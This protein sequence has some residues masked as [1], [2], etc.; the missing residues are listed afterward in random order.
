VKQPS[1]DFKLKIQKALM[2]PDSKSSCCIHV[3]VP[4]ECNVDTLVSLNIEKL[5]FSMFSRNS[6]IAIPVI[7]A[8]WP[9]VIILFSKAGQLIVFGILPF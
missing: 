8:V 1:T 9:G 7:L 2:L 5:I 4:C 3:P 6:L